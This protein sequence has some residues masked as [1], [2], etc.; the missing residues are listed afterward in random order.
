MLMNISNLNDIFKLYENVKDDL[1]FLI[2]SDVRMKILINLDENPQNIGQLKKELNLNSSTILHGI[3]QLEKKHLITRESGNYSLTPT[4][5]IYRYKLMDMVKSFAA[6]ETCE[7]IFLKHNINCIPIELLKDMG[8]LED[9]HIISSITTDILRPHKVLMNY[10]HQASTIKIISS[11]LYT[12]NIELIFSNLDESNIHLLLTREILDTI[13]EKVD[14]DYIKNSLAQGN[15]KLGVINQ[16]TKICFTMGDNFI[17]LGL[18]FLNGEYDLN[19]LLINENKNGKYW[20]ER[21][22][23]YYQDSAIDFHRL[24]VS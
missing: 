23:K 17:T 7:N 9:S 12:P 13:L 5:K 11:I 3:Y 22:F 18:Y 1:K 15:L 2:K 16:D 4:G 20:G 24:N 21:L 8:C 14:N 19:N 6:L 10:L